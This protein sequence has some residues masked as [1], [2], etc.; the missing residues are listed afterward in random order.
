MKS[1]ADVD[2]T[3]HPFAAVGAL[4]VARV[5]AAALLDA[6]QGQNQAAEMLEA[7]QDLVQRVLGNEELATFLASAAVGREKKA[8]VIDAAFKDRAAPLLVDFLQVLNN[9]NRLDILRPIAASY[10][11]QLDRRN[12]LVRV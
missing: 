9:H 2:T 7:L 3:Q 8:Q 4:Q 5:Y 12:N 10:K 11:E 1:D 6:A